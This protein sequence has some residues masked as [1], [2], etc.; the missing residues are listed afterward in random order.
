V[1]VEVAGGVHRF[2]SRYVNWYVVEQGGKLTLVDAGLPGQWRQLLAALDGLG[3]RL[4]DV[5]AI[6]LTHAHVDHTGFAER[7]RREAGAQVWVHRA[8]APSRGRRFPPPRAFL[9]PTSWPYAVHGTRE[10]LLATPPVAELRSFDDGETLDLPGRPTVLHTPG[11]TRGNCSL[12]L[13]AA[14]VLFTGDAMVTLDPYTRKTGPRVLIDEVN[15]DTGQAVASL[16]RLEGVDAD[17]LLPGHGEPWRQGPAA[18]VAAARAAA[19]GG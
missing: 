3:R 5:E 17:L 18:A 1:L 8:D 19:A 13:P 12:H 10:R 15:E 7:G 4:G 2:G 16:G 6:V 9:R 14:G 11:H